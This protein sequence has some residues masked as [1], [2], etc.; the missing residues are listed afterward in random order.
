VILFLAALSLVL[1]LVLGADWFWGMRRMTVLRGEAPKVER[2][3]TLSVVVPARN[4]AETVGASL[5]SLL[6]QDYPALEVIV[7]EDRSSDATGER[8]RA[9]AARYPRLE[10]L[11]VT[12]LPEGWLGKNHALQV[13]A[14]RATGEWLLFTDADVRYAPGA[15]KATVAYALR[16]RL[17]HLAALPHFIAKSVFL[18]SFVSAFA[19][20]FSVYT[21]LWRVKDTRSRAHIG[22]GAFGLVRREAYERV[23]GH[24]AIA[25]RPDDDLKLGKLLKA[26]GYRQ[27]A[28]FASELLAVEWYGSVPEAV[29]G[30]EKNAFAGLGYSL[31]AVFAVCGLLLAT[32]V[33]PFV[34]VWLTSGLAQLLFA[35]SVVT[36]ALVYG[37]NARFAKVS[38]L[39]FALHPYAVTVLCYAALRSSLTA[40]WRGEIRW[41]DTAY[42]L[43]AL[44]K[45]KV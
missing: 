37:Y 22:I 29:R 13:G 23:G 24:R 33:L 45:N 43:E 19:L 10:V 30:L 5:P 38:P 20:L 41:R 4:E 36:V 2:W 28:V 39:Y 3:P 12:S 15:L 14:K 44:R 18:R 25:L 26:H 1:W 8:L 35:A 42:P 16:G 27:E 21:R 9:L 11:Y 17:D 32:N 40:L 7:I 34:A 31:P 6:E